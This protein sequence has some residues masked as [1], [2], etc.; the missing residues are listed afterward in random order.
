MKEIMNEAEKIAAQA[1]NSYYQVNGSVS[2]ENNEEILWDMVVIT[3]VDHVIASHALSAG[4][5]LYGGQL[6]GRCGRTGVFCQRGAA[7][8]HGWRVHG[9]GIVVYVK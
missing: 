7:V 2:Q 6:Y 8:D 5:Q 9:I 4:A 1:K 3:V